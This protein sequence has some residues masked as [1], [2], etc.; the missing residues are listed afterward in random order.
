MPSA[1]LA[2]AVRA[3]A[4]RALPGRARRPGRPSSS[5][6]GSGGPPSARSRAPPRCGRQ[7]RTDLPGL[8]LAGA[9]TDTGWPD[10]M[11]GAV[12][13]GLTA[14]IDCAGAWL[15]PPQRLGNAVTA[16]MPEG[17][18]LARD[19]VGPAMESA[20][21]RLTPDV[22]AVAAYHL[23]FTDAAGAAD[24]QRK[25]RQGAAARAGPAVGPGRGRASRA[26]RDRRGRGRA[27]AQLLPAARRHH[28][29]RPRAPAPAHGLDR[30]RRRPGHPR[31]ATPCSRWPRTCCS[32]TTRSRVPGPPAACPR[33][34]S[35]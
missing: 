27:R 18:A 7:A 35:G 1:A 33:P 3:R 29:Q 26:G 15:L 11:E 31:R 21:A 22:R 6:P 16:V 30:V 34:C 32:R 2:R 19:L 17:V 8:V 25:R 24:R 9:W 20:I 23:G 14:A 13:S 5:L 12:R 28:G 4:G 10:T